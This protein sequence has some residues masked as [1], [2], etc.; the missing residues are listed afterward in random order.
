[1]TE[2]REYRR[3]LRDLE[4]RLDLLGSYL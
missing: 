1:M 3:Q 2:A 4:E